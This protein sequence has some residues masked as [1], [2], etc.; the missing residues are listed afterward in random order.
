M[1]MFVITMT[2]FSQHVYTYVHNDDHHAQH[3]M[4]GDT[5]SASSWARFVSI[6][7]H[8]DMCNMSMMLMTIIKYHRHHHHTLTMIDDNDDD[9]NRLHQVPLRFLF[10]LSLACC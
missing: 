1:T 9:A 7:I 4:A 3:M 10:I 2:C 6:R 8:S 5:S